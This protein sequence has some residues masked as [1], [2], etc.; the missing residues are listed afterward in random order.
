MMIRTTP[1]KV[2]RFGGKFL[3]FRMI[4]SSEMKLCIDDSHIDALHISCMQLQRPFADLDL[5]AVCAA[6]SYVGT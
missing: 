2:P 3:S 4:L 5:T 6:V 1:F